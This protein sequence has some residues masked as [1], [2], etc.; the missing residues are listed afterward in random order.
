M[1]VSEFTE[2]NPI[3]EETRRKLEEHLRALEVR[4]MVEAFE[5][6]GI[7]ATPLEFQYQGDS[8]RHHVVERGHC[9]HCQGQIPARRFSIH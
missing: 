2:K 8:L 7:C 3:T 1:K 9:P 5:N 4:R 6:C